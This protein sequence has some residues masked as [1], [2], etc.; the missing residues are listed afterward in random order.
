MK[1]TPVKF[2]SIDDYIATFPEDVQK[3]LNELRATIHAAA[4]GA[5]EKISYHMPGFA[6]NGNLV[7]FAAFKNHIGFFGGSDAGSAGYKK[8]WAKYVGPKGSLK[9]PLDKPLPLKLVSKVVK[10]RVAENKKKAKM[11][12]SKKKG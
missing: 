9:F 8:E 2:A 1:T 12:A 11:S 5:E 4:P 3:K 6:L 10:I 7:Y